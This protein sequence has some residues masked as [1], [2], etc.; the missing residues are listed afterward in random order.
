ML[1]RI[2]YINHLNEAMEWGTGGIYVN[3]N[4][5]RNY[6]WDYTKENDKISYFSQSI[7]KKS[8]PIII[9][10][11]SET[12]GIELKNKLLEI[13]EKDVLA[14]Q[15]G[16]LIIGDYYLK[17]FITG[18]KKSDY[19][20]KKGYMKATLTIVTDYPQ[21]VKETTTIFRTITEE[22]K[23]GKRNL[24]FNVDFPSDYA[25]ELK[26]KV[27]TNTSF[28]S[29]NFRMSIYGAV[30]NPV[31]FIAGHRYQINYTV[32]VG[33]TLTVDSLE[34]TVILTKRNG[35][36]VN[37]FNFRER[38]SYIFEQIPS[39]NNVVNWNGEFDF[40]ITLIEQRSEPKWT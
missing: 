3:S 23:E 1:E 17:C 31:I 7:V 28:V 40:D 16:K 10:C 12:E 18:S 19:L 30:V 6:S 13:G 15:H 9:C 20:I 22:T 4:D 39:G 11:S 32:E 38:E 29:T 8:V 5:L 2:K 25:S 27:L 14:T 26:G 36:Q 34:K 33:E 24:D 37:C 35:E 21:W